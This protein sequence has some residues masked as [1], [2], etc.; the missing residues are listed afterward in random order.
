MK[1]NIYKITVLNWNEHNLS[2]RK[3]FKKTLIAN[4]FCTDAKIQSLPMTTRWL[5]LNLLLT[6]GDTCGDTL[7]LSAQRLRAMLECN[8]NVDGVL[9]EL[10]SL[11]LVTWEKT[12]LIEEKLKEIKVKERK[13][14]AEAKEKEIVSTQVSKAAIRG[15]IDEFS[16]DEVCLKFLENVT[17]KA[18]K[19]W[20]SAYPSIDWICH[21]I[22][23]A[24]AWCET[25]SHK[26]PKDRGRFM[27]TWLNRGFE[28]YRKT[29]QSKQKIHDPNAELREKFEREAA[30]ENAFAE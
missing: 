11:R 29:L 15:A 5:F 19:S 1:K 14:S 22:R 23:K 2:H 21:E 16:H 9:D 7:E 26:A 17:H 3:S 6:C 27:L 24:N 25:N 10:Q 28:N 13:V 30:N 8:R 18:Q 20:L 4:D 12:S